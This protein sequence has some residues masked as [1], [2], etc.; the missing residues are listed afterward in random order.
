MSQ[1]AKV[2]HQPA[3]LIVDDE[4]SMREALQDLIRQS[5]PTL[6]VV[7]AHDGATALAHFEAHQ[8][9][10]VLV[11]K[12]LPDT[13]GLDL[14]RTIK[15]LNPATLVAV[16]S[17]E[18]NAHIAAQ[19]LAAGAVAFVGKDKLFDEVVPLVGAAVSLQEWVR[20]GAGVDTR[21]AAA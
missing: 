14:T 11:D 8:P 7:D 12:N 19:A 21:P 20:P 18:T 2:A 13:S 1:L 10:F 9:L 16:I 4:A 5:F 3:V 15:K 17:V 6:R